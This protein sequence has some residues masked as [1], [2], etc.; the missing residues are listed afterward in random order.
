MSDWKFGSTATDWI[1]GSTNFVVPEG[2]FAIISPPASIYRGETV[3]LQ[4]SGVSGAPSSATLDGQPLEIEEFSSNEIVFTAPLETLA[5][6]GTGK[7]VAITVAGV[8][9]Q[10]SVAFNA[11]PGRLVATLINPE[12][13]TGTIYQGMTNLDTSSPMDPV[14]GGQVIYSAETTPNQNDEAYPVLI[15]ADG[16]PE[17]DTQ[18]AIL[19][20]T[21]TFKRQY[22]LPGVGISNDGTITVADYVGDGLDDTPDQ[23]SFTPVTGATGGASVTATAPI[24]GVD[25]GATLTAVGFALSNNGGNTWSSSV[26]YVPG[27]TLVRATV[28]A[29]ATPGGSAFQ[30]GSVNGVEATFSVTTAMNYVFRAAQP[31]SYFDA[32]GNIVPLANVSS[33]PYAI[34]RTSDGGVISGT[35]LKSGT[36]A[37]N[38]LGQIPD[39]SDP[40]F[41]LGMQVQVVFLPPNRSV[42]VNA[43]IVSGGA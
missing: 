39:I 7:I 22:L 27:A 12:G 32:S 41:T 6:H 36:I 5:G 37:T 1:F 38:A 40:A 24:T 2:D 42:V 20:G 30:T 28:T 35:R 34:F 25:F 3:A 21:E 11:G 15:G 33:I 4:C 19:D 31:L 43:S 26:S 17:I 10:F 13:G 14:T 18:G 8:T 29:S 9:Q 16:W 23:F